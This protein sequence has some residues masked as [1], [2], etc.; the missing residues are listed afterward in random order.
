MKRM[1]EHAI[2]FAREGV[3]RRMM[4][5]EVAE[6][7]QVAHLEKGEEGEEGKTAV[8]TRAKEEVRVVDPAGGERATEKEGEELKVNEAKGVET[9]DELVKRDMVQEAKGE[10]VEMKAKEESKGATAEVTELEYEKEGALAKPQ[11]YED[12]DPHIP[13]G[14]TPNANEEDSPRNLVCTKH[15]LR[16]LLALAQ[17]P[18]GTT[19]GLRCR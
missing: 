17:L 14:L 2:M 5:R 19:P 8:E 15:I 18:L 4:A 7:V 10:E 3:E 1:K 9:K 6:R 13:P 12:N 16:P 11:S